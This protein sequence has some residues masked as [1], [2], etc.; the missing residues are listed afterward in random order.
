MIAVRRLAL[1]TL[2][3]AAWLLAGC[4]SATREPPAP[5]ERRYTETITSV[6]VSADEQRIAAIGSGHHYI[7]GA[8]EM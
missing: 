7:F 2:A 6:L 1:A 8:P 5:Q 3:A 4:A